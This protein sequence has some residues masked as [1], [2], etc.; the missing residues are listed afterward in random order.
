[1][2]A[3][4]GERTRLE[5]GRGGLIQRNGDGRVT[6]CNLDL[7]IRTLVRPSTTDPGEIVDAIIEN[8]RRILAIMEEIKATIGECP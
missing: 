8:E 1:M 6:A 2:E 4:A 7:K 3:T 5:G